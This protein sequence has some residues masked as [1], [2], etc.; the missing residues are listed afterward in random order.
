MKKSWT[1]SPPNSLAN[2]VRPGTTPVDSSWQCTRTTSRMAT[3][4]KRSSDWLRRVMACGRYGR[5]IPRCH[6]RKRAPP[7]ADM[8]E[9]AD[10]RRRRRQQHGVDVPFIE[11]LEE[12]VDVLELHG[13]V[14]GHV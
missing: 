3:P 12:L 5:A 10:R 1:P 6:R 2:Q 8:I 13:A 11:D 14:I 4:R 7:P 9:Q